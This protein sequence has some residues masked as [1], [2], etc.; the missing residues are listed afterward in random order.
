MTFV[1]DKH[2]VTNWFAKPLC[3][4]NL[5]LSSMFSARYC[6]MVFSSCVMVDVVVE[7]CMSEAINFNC[8]A[9]KK[10]VWWLAN[11][12]KDLLNDC[13]LVLC[14]VRS[15]WNQ[16]LET[17]CNDIRDILLLSFE[18]LSYRISNILETILRYNQFLMFANNLWYKYEIGVRLLFSLATIGSH[19]TKVEQFSFL[20]IHSWI[21]FKWHICK[22][23][24]PKLNA[25]QTKSLKRCDE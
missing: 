18:N 4:K 9:Q 19:I 5:Q 3:N 23:L 8:W 21:S 24:I 14:W 1:H 11:T 20:Q 10:E 17:T 15:N 13:E 12:T 25:F 2:D 22:T 16:T 7:S 6:Y